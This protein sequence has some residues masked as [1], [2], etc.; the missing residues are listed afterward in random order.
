MADADTRTRGKQE[1]AVRRINQRFW[2]LAG[3]A[4]FVLVS[5]RCCSGSSSTSENTDVDEVPSAYLWIV[6]TLIEEGS[7]YDI[8]TAGGFLVFYVVQIAG[9]SL[10]AFVSGA[11]ASKLVT[12]VMQ[13]GEGH[14]FDQRQ[15]PRR[16]LRL[17]RQGRRDHPRAARPRGARTRAGSWCWPTSR[18]IRPRSTTSSSSAGTRATRPTC[19]APASTAARWPSCW[20]TSRRRPPPT[21]SGRPHPVHR[22]GRRDG[23]R[24]RLHA[25]SR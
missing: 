23:E 15:G 3:L 1:R 9:I 16:D 20:P 14:G 18:T 8:K 2:Q 25:A 22:A 21:P 11:I 10:V 13:Q 7:A 24:R 12:T 19:S 17:E 6:R 4:L 5:R